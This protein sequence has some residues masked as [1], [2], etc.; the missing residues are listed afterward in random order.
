MSCLAEPPT[1]PQEIDHMMN[2]LNRFHRDAPNERVPVYLCG[3]ISHGYADKDGRVIHRHD[4]LFEHQIPYMCEFHIKNTDSIYQN[5]FGFSLEEQQSGI[6]HL[7]DLKDQILRNASRWPRDN[8]IGYLEIG[9]PKR[10]RDY[11]DR[12][13]GEDLSRSLEA[14][15][16]VFGFS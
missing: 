11:S 15:T 4:E 2:I 10:G 7:K 9:G 16:K 13:L 3:D 5:T 14:I 12:K 6:I 1:L 8:P